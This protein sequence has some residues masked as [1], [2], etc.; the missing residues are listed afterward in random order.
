[1][2]D[3]DQTEPPG[4][5]PRALAAFVRAMDRFAEWCGLAFCWLILPLVAGITYEV[6]ARYVF[7]APTVWSYDVA[8]MLYGTHFMLGAAY[9][10]KRGGHIR[11]DVFYQN[12]SFRTRGLIDASL[13]LFFFFPGMALFLWMGWQ[14]ALHSWE[15][16]E[17]SGES[18]W[19]PI[20]YPFKTVIP[21]ACALLILQGMSEFAKSAW[22]ALKGRP[23]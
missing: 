21:V 15:L 17:V 8:Y 6:F 22:A 14:E 3:P 16:R 11:T 18:P 23:L 19:R 13:Y 9:T 20:I 2:S 7:R 12:W 5:P 10:L 1:M 4:A